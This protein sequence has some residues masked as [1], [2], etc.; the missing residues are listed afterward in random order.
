MFSS[1]FLK[2]ILFMYLLLAVLGLPCCLDFSLV[3]AS[4]GYSLV[5]VCGLLMVVASLVGGNRL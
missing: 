5:V 2:I 3:V 1:S 4:G